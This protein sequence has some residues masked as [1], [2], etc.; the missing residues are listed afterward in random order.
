MCFTDCRNTKEKSFRNSEESSM[1]ILNTGDKRRK[2]HSEKQK[3][4]KRM[5]VLGILLIT[6][7]CVPFTAIAADM[8][9]YEDLEASYEQAGNANEANEEEFRI[10]VE[11]NNLS[12]NDSL[13]SEWWNI[14]LLGTDTGGKLNYGRTDAMLILSVH[15]DTGEIKLT[16]LIR[17]MWV[18]IPGMKAPNR[19]NAANAFGGPY[20]AMKTVN[21]IL[22]QNIK[23]YCSVNFS[24]L[25]RLVDIIGDVPL[26]IT[27]TEARLI[28]AQLHDGVADLNGEQ[29]LEYARIRKLD[30]NFGRNERQRNLLTGIANQ[31]LGTMDSIMILNA[32]TEM[33]PYVDTNLTLSDIF[34][35]VRLF[36]MNQSLAIDMLNLPLEDEFH[37]GSTNGIGHVCFDQETVQQEL[38]AFIYE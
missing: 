34:K 29:A 14:L 15:T 13:P 4:C 18:N 31:V 10:H 30:S 35:F 19:I 8:L 3:L 26:E 36:G 33:L 6:A 5:S 24:G 11:H 17:D 28:G 38:Y 23:H 22:S 9:L 32:I 7:V 1:N 12:I 27:S 37:Y 2:D 20:L 16:S 21:M 25:I